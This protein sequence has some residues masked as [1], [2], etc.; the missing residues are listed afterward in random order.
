MQHYRL[1]FELLSSDS[2]K[3][4][5]SQKHAFLV[6]RYLDGLLKRQNVEPNYTF[7]SIPA[8]LK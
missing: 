8:F 7:N 5:Q 4:N 2:N 1:L 6:Q 3:L